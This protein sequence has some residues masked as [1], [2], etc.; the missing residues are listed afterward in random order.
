VGLPLA[1]AVFWLVNP[2]LW[3]HPWE[4]F[5]AFLDLNVHRAAHP[6][7]NVTTCFFGRLYDLHFPLP[8]YNTLFWTGV[9]VPLGLLGLAAVGVGCVLWRRPADLAGPLLVAQW[10]VLLVVRALPWAPPHDAERLILPSFAFLAA[11][12]GIGAARLCKVGRAERANAVSNRTP[13][14]PREGA[15]TRS[16]RSTTAN[17]PQSPSARFCGV[18]AV[19]LIYAASA[20]SLSWYSPQWLSYYNLLIGGLRGATA[21]GMEPT[22][23]WDGL[24]RTV[25]AWLEAHSGPEEKVDFATG[26]WENLELMRAW[27]TLPRD[28]RPEGPGEYRWYV[29]QCRPSAWQPADRWLVEHARPAFV[30]TIRAGGLGPWRLDVPLVLVY[31]YGQYLE[32]VETAG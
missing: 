10:L 17:D 19:V 1:L 13:H 14:A 4:G 2:P 22:Y 24:D 5:R 26:A 30:K 9:T 3:H 8:W 15:L 6:A 31:S 32:A 11:L 27:G 25:L 21:L 7:L 20:A 16:V 28:Y 12:A 18:A 23:Y 29:V